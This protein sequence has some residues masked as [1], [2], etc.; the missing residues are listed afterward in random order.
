VALWRADA[1]PAWAPVAFLV[2]FSL[3]FVLP[4]AVPAV[5]GFALTAALWLAALGR[6]GLG[7]LR[8]P[9]G[10]WRHG[11]SPLP[12]PPAMDGTSQPAR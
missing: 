11:P 12:A 10:R 7:M 2:G 5:V 4:G 3:E 9:D 1:A 8:M 6:V